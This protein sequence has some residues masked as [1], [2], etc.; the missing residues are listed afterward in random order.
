MT[1][2]LG[3][4][5]RAVEHDHTPLAGRQRIDRTSV[6]VER[7]DPSFLG[8]R[9]IAI[10]DGLGSTVFEATR[11]FE[12]RRGAGALALL[13]HQGIESRLTHGETALAADVRG[14]VQ[15]KAIRI[16]ERERRL[17]R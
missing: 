10:E 7:D 4:E 9:P 1:A 8:K 2:R 15:R 3:I 14:E 16:V 12:A 13:F 11:H 5:R 6:A 17:A